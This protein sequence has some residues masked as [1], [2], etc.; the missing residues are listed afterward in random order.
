M[1]RC[2]ARRH[3]RYGLGLGAFDCPAADEIYR[4]TLKA[5]AEGQA[6]FEWAER[7][8]FVLREER[9]FLAAVPGTLPRRFE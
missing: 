2:A 3:E 1:P 7:D 9:M 5:D 4:N 8:R 6:D